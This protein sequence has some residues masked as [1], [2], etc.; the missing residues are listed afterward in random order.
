MVTHMIFL[1]MIASYMT[2]GE[3]LTASEYNT[4]SFFNPLNN[5]SMA[6][7]SYTPHWFKKGEW[8]ILVWNDLAG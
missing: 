3:A 2:Y 5:A 6:I 1:K 4:L 7:C 8:K